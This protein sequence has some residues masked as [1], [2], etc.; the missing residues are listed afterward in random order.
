MGADGAP[1]GWIAA[2]LLRD[3][4]TGAERTELRLFADIAAL[5]AD[6]VPGVVVG[7]DV[8]I[9]L[10]ETGPRACDREA[11]RILGPRASS[12]FPAPNRWMLDHTDDYAGLR[13]HVSAQRVVGVELASLSAQGHGI[14]KKIK[15]VDDW[16]AAN[17]SAD[18]WLLECHPEVSFLALNGGRHLVD[19]KKT[20]EGK[21]ARRAV[22]ARAF[23]DAP[24][25]LDAAAGQWRRAA[26]GVDDLHDAY[27]CL[28][29]ALAVLD[30]TAQSLGDGSTDARGRPMRM[31]T[32][33]IP[34]VG[35]D[36]TP[37]GEAPAPAVAPP[38]N[39]AP[40]A[41]PA[42]REASREPRTD[43]SLRA[44]TAADVEFIVAAERDPEARPFIS[45]SSPEEHRALIAGASHEVLIVEAGGQRAGFIHRTAVDRHGVVELSRLAITDRGAGI[46]RAALALAI[47]HVFTTTEAHR[48][49]LDVLPHNERARRTYAA[50]G[51]VEEGTLRDA[52]VSPTG[53]RASLTILSIL[54]PEWAARTARP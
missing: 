37:V 27:A 9:G 38:V 2:C 50:A 26:V 10:L 47:D 43:V 28:H 19:A 22:I 4:A 21:A 6:H 51:F 35:V 32:A 45:N 48:L 3:D 15:E 44:A 17:P 52:W 40:P 12:V 33:R 46:G 23:P 24:T 8:P 1:G 39:L 42:P 25:Q 49:W 34:E 13:A 18:V 30:G 16:L 31:V 7:I 20:P 14:T 5:A 36:D 53:T 11:R 29:S 41:G 54:R